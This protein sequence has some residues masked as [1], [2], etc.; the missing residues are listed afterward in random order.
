MYDLIDECGAD[1]KHLGYEQTQQGKYSL[2]I[3]KINVNSE[4]KA[5]QTGFDKGCYMIFNAPLMHGYRTE[6]EEYISQQIAKGI[7]SLLRRN[8]LGKKSRLLLVGLGNPAILADSIG[9][10]VLDKINLDV[11]NKALRVFKFAPNVFTNTGINSFDMV[12]VLSL[13][14]D[15]DGVI[16]FDALGTNSA[17]R[18]TTSVQINDVGMTPA[19]AV[20]NLGN[21]LCKETLG[22]PCIS[23]G[24]PTMLLAGK[25]S[26]QFPKNLILTPKDIHTELDT[27]TNIISQAIIQSI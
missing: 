16:I 17:S 8:S 4:E 19:S 25:V 26:S 12:H 14:L 9:A 21:K 2:S 27:L 7:K 13:W 3:G 15:V 1:L 23:V 18:L 11:F 6:C 10:Q 20:N 24:V 22:V 5:Q